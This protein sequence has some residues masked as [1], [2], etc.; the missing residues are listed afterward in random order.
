MVNFN[1]FII[2]DKSKQYIS[3]LITNNML[4]LCLI[5]NIET[6]KTT[7]IN[8]IIDTFL[9]NDKYEVYK[10][11][12]YKDIGINYF[13]QDVHFFCKSK[14]IKKKVIV[15]D[16]IDIIK[17]CSQHILKCIIETYD[18]IQ[19]LFA[20]SNITKVYESIIDRI[21]MIELKQLSTYDDKS[22]IL[23]IYCHDN[24]YALQDCAKKYILDNVEYQY[25]S[26]YLNV[27]KTLKI[28]N[29]KNNNEAIDNINSIISDNIFKEYYNYIRVGK[30]K[31]AINVL[32]EVNNSYVSLIDLLEY[33]YNYSKIEIKTNEDIFVN[34][35]KIIAEY[36][37]IFNIEYESKI[38][39]YFLSYDIH[40]VFEKHKEKTKL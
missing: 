32:E 3:S 13:R 36:K 23:D 8:I 4:K 40:N 19:F 18:N 1:N 15:I 22:N 29:I 30:I 34:V 25:P 35:I 26:S 11:E 14:T 20:C 7:L 12:Q 28:L 31:E 38:E 39:L 6:G 16:N 33:L 21:Y 37:I 9:T 5:G 24:E 10:V 2:D 17:E 27:V